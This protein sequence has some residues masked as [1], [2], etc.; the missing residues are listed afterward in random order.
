MLDN[1]N[2]QAC[3]SYILKYGK[4]RTDKGSTYFELK[5]Q[6]NT[7]FTSKKAI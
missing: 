7:S 6:H 2:I 4:A 5:I 1:S 3:G